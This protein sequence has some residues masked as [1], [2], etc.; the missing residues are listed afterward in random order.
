M[1]SH[2][3]GSNRRKSIRPKLVAAQGGCCCYCAIKFDDSNCWG[4]RYPT[5][6]HIQDR[7][8]GG[9]NAQTNLAMAC[10]QC[11]ERAAHER[12]SYEFKRA[13]IRAANVIALA[14]L[15]VEPMELPPMYLLRAGATA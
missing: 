7:S 14:D 9:V 13:R 2:N 15:E 5:F 4:E 6:E 11:N 3:L 8:K 10:R 1:P 12:W